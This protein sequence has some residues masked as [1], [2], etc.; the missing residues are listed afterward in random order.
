MCTIH[1]SPG[2]S[3]RGRPALKPLVPAPRLARMTSPP[4]ADEAPVC[5]A[6]GCR[7]PALWALRWNNPRLHDA[8]RRKTWLA[9][10]DHRES[11]GDFL[12]A[13]G[14]LREVVPAPASPTLEG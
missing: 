2:G 5:S 8:D 9:C 12:A 7:A 3:P 1:P 11:L 6:R 10:A 13:R 4:P 14:F